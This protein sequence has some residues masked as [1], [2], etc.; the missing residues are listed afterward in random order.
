[1]VWSIPAAEVG[2]CPVVGAQYCSVEVG[3]FSFI[4]AGSISGGGADSVSSS[5]IGLKSL[6]SA[7]TG[8]LEVER[9]VTGA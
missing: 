2:S 3:V 8:R 7:G 5:T 6:V 1:M 9:V 4:G